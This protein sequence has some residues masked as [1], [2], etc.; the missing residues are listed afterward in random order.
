MRR[1]LIVLTSA[2]LVVVGLAP[3]SH[4]DATRV[5]RSFGAPEGYAEIGFGCNTTLRTGAGL[6]YR[7][8]EATDP[9]PTLGERSWGHDLR[10]YGSGDF[11]GL[12]VDGASAADFDTFQLKVYGAA[13][14]SGRAMVFSQPPGTA[15]ENVW[16]GTA[17]I[18]G[19]GDAWATVDASDLAYSWAEYDQ[20]DSYTPTGATAGSLTLAA[21]DTEKGISATGYFAMMGFGCDGQGFYYDAFAWGSTGNVT[22]LDFE[23][24][25]STTTIQATKP[26]I[27]AGGTTTITGQTLAHFLPSTPVDLEVKAYGSST[28]VKVG[29]YQAPETSD[30]K[31][32]K[33]V[34]P[35]R[36]TSYR[37][38]YRGSESNLP[39]YSPAVTIWVKTALSAAIADTTLRRGQN[40]AVSGRAKPAKPGATVTLWRKTATGSTVLARTRVKADGTY[41]VVCPVNRIGTWTVYTTIPAA[42]GNLAGRSVNRA[43]KVT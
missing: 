7:Y 40:L 20:T 12:G 42:S 33:T 37:W 43:A 1:I 22:T 6:H 21:F 10:Q 39:A 23:A 38:H 8:L 18:G 30:W 36:Q 26:T 32:A 16:I 35:L 27:T 11:F 34:A 15:P 13:A 25:L 41:K 31:L 17:V 3:A 5:I 29:T 14:G 24:L 19:G 28:W 9:A 4:A 2:L